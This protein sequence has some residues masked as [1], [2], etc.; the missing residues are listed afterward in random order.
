MGTVSEQLRDKVDSFLKKYKMSANRFGAIVSGDT[1][2]VFDLR[3]GARKFQPRTEARVEAFIDIFERYGLTFAD[4][5]SRVHRL[6]RDVGAPISMQAVATMLNPNGVSG[7]VPI[8]DVQ[9]AKIVDVSVDEAR[10]LLEEAAQAEIGELRKSRYWCL[11]VFAA[12]P[13]PLA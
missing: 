10:V 1:R 11:T 12:A 9:V 8:R 3:S 13:E 2:L 6:A 5:S 7:T 4:V